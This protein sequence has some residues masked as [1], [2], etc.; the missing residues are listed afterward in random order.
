MQL[1]AD[2][3]TGVARSIMMAQQNY[4][5]RHFKLWKK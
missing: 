5:D 1:I 3:E 4:C 2:A